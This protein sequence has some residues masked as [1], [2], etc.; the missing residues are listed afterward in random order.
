MRKPI[1]LKK[2]LCVL[3][4]SV[5]VFLCALA[6]AGAQAGTGG[7]NAPEQREKPYLILVSL[8]GFRADYLDRFRLPNLGR[9]MKRGARA[10]WMNPVFPSLTF[11][12]HYSLVTG[13]HP[14]KHGIVG[15]SFYDPARRQKYAMHE[16]AAVTDGTWYRGEPIWVTAETQG[17]VAACYFWPGSEAAI[18]GVRPTFFM[19]Y[20]EDTPNDERVK[21]ALDWLRLP[22]DRRPHVITLYFSELDT[23]SHRNALDS[24][25]I[26]SA[27]RSLDTSIGALI[28]GI[29]ALPFGSQVNL[30][31]T[32]DHGMVDT[33]WS[34]SIAIESVVDLSGVVQT[35]VGPVTSFHVAGNDATRAGKLRD[36]LNAR[37]RHGR[38]Y[39][40]AELPERYHFAADPRAGDVVVV[41]DE[42]WTL[43]R[44]AA[45]L[46][47][48]GRRGAHGWDPAV[49]AMRAIFVAMGP[50]I[51]AGTVIDPIDNVDVYPFMTEL[52][53]LRPAN[54]I[55]GQS[56]RIAAMVK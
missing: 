21:R 26:E 19:P 24:P 43:K 36:D 48:I 1:L 41:M 28:D 35:F 56:G 20:D 42:P 32:S 30:V 46:V 25:R 5:F 12:N 54:G 55:D 44:A 51:R 34:R 47:Q 3:C 31:I 15:N 2:A 38:A 52:L 45:K 22:A 4:A 9:V 23:A 11:P 39:L 49:P 27:A 8:D 50:E 17:M 7:V 10:K 33:S 40:R 13:L 6:L 29:D 53:G 18:N 16:G 37:L 14:E